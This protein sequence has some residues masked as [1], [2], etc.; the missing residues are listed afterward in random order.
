KWDW[1]ANFFHQGEQESSAPPAP[2]TWPKFTPPRD[3]GKSSLLNPKPSQPVA[4]GTTCGSIGR[5]GQCRRG[6]KL[7]PSNTRELKDLVLIGSSGG[8]DDVG[9]GGTEEEGSRASAL[10]STL[11]A[12]ALSSP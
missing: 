7:Y 10:A 8:A 9:G 12:A 4:A 3:H 11:P 1:A 5:G 6:E 2:T